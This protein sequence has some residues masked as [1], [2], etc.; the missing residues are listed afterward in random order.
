MQLAGTLTPSGLDLLPPDF[1]PCWKL[2]HPTGGTLGSSSHQLPGFSP[3]RLSNS[4]VAKSSPPF[5]GRS[6]HCLASMFLPSRFGEAGKLGP[7]ASPT[8]LHSLLG[9]LPSLQEV[10]ALEALLPLYKYIT[11]L[12]AP[13][14]SSYSIL[15]SCSSTPPF[16]Q[17]EVKIVVKNMLEFESSSS[18][19]GL[20]GFSEVMF[21]SFNWA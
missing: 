19:Y 10:Q 18:V 20:W 17:I 5:G 8:R 4:S 15:S 14:P 11:C 9:L 3:P 13:I 7:S 1:T 2:L 12:P 6:S 21:L 16:F